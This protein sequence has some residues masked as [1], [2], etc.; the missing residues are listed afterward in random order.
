VNL[1]G[2]KTRCLMFVF[3]LSYSGKA[4]HRPIDRTNGVSYLGLPARRRNVSVRG[5]IVVEGGWFNAAA[6]GSD[7]Q[8]RQ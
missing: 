8:G 2:A 3:R 7:R 6:I 5:C 1:A 4:I